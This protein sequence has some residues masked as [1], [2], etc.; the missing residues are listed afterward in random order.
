M[1]ERITSDE[2][3]DVHLALADPQFSFEVFAPTLGQRLLEAALRADQLAKA[4]K[5]DDGEPVLASEW[6]DW[7]EDW[8]RMA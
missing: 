4:I 3:L 8:G 7:R 6:E 2:V 1:D 5:W